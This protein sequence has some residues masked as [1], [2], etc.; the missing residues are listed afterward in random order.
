MTNA[1]LN[2]LS[3]LTLLT[4]L[5][6]TSPAASAG[7][8][9]YEVQLGSVAAALLSDPTTP[10]TFHQALSEQPRTLCGRFLQQDFY[11]VP[12]EHV[13][14][15]VEHDNRSLL[16]V[17]PWP[18]PI[19]LSSR[20]IPELVSPINL[21]EDQANLL[22]GTLLPNLDGHFSFAPVEDV[23][24]GQKVLTTWQAMADSGT[25]YSCWDNTCGILVNSI[26]LTSGKK[27]RGLAACEVIRINSVVSNP[28]NCNA[29]V[30]RSEYRTYLVAITEFYDSS[31]ASMGRT[32]FR[33]SLSDE[34]GLHSVH[35]DGLTSNVLNS[36]ASFLKNSP[37]DMEVSVA[38]NKITGTADNLYISELNFWTRQ[39]VTIDRRGVRGLTGLPL[40]EVIT[41]LYVSPRNSSDPN[42]WHL[43]N[44]TTD[45]MYVA[46]LKSTV[47]TAINSICP[48]AK[49]SLDGIGY[50][51][52][53]GG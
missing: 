25:L 39:T 10:L 15:Q 20:R 32:D 47:T 42:E 19:P 9:V 40:Y 11:C 16:V 5:L 31:Y 30:L 13:P 18:A 41:T 3:S 8:N 23:I 43:P 22:I 35:V 28:T 33:F 50:I 52:N 1:K 51:F 17:K 36:I 6:T 2:P 29:I 21:S 48:G 12:N 45:S 44:T 49:S 7:T 37:F 4:V 34:A 38:D 24:N 53:C 26:Y 27:Y 46:M 14:K